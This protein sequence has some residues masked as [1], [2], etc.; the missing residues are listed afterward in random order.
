M[1]EQKHRIAPPPALIRPLRDFLHAEAS[2]G[3]VLVIG[4]AIALIWANSPWSQSYHDLWA[5]RASIDI[6]S[7]GLH[8]DLRHWI[9]DGLMAIFFFVVGLEIKRELVE[10]ELSDKRQ[11]ALP[12]LAAL[13]GMVVPALVYLAFTLGTE[14]THGWGIPMAT[15]I[16]LAVG[17]LGLL[18]SR[19]PPA[20]KIFVLALAIVDDI[21]AI[22][23]IAVAYT[24]D[25]HFGW[26]GLAAA[27]LAATVIAKKLDIQKIGAYVVIGT[28][29]WVALHEAGIHATLAGVAM[30]LLAP[31]LPRVAS[32]YIDVEEFRNVSDV[33]AVQ[34]TVMLARESVS[35]VEWLENRLHPLSSFVIVP[36]FALAN[37]GIEI[38]S[39]GLSESVTSKVALGVAAGLVIGKPLGITLA[40]FLGVKLGLELPKGVTMRMV[41]ALGCIAGIG[42]T[43]ALFITELAFDEATII[44]ESKLAILVASALAAILG[45]VLVVAGSRPRPNTPAAVSV[46]AA[47]DTTPV[48]T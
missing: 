39:S 46:D 22:A 18:G 23:V 21:G 29:L 11:A 41:T 15:D 43:V 42:F 44:D 20:G 1:A 28:M 2:G 45:C 35:V 38:T 10:G 40:T 33:T 34:Q 32:D 48:T 30:G 6:G 7:F 3:I 19:V 31:A 37:S 24:E 12:A 9:N 36:L 16:A 13:G 27:C 14:N 25:L 5:T 47:A 17:I 4:A 8:L 26:L